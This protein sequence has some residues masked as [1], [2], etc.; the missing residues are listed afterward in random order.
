VEEAQPLVHTAVGGQRKAR[1]PMTFDDQVVQILALLSGETVQ[2]KVIQDQ[3]VRSQVA[4][5]DALEG[6]VAAGLAKVFEQRVG[7]GEDHAVAGPDG[8][9]AECL[10]QKGLPYADGSN[11]NDVLLAL[12]ELESEDVL[13]L[14]TIH[15]HR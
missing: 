13:E 6:V 4:A 7:A 1:V 14:L 5:K 3:Q 9:S 11:H 12:E 2:R 10:D 15:V 8:G